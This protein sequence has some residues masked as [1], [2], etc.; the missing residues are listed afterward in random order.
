ME[1][2]GLV[3]KDSLDSNARS[4]TTSDIPCI[5][6]MDQGTVLSG[7]QLYDG[8]LG[9][10]DYG[11]IQDIIDEYEANNDGDVITAEEVEALRDISS[12]FANSATGSKGILHG[13]S[14]RFPE[15]K[16]LQLTLHAGK[17]DQS[18][19]Q[20]LFGIATADDFL[21]QQ[22]YYKTNHLEYWT[23]KHKLL[24]TAY[25]V[26]RDT[27][28]AEDG[29]SPAL[30]F[31]TRG[32][33]VN[34]FSYDGSYRISQ[35]VHTSLE[36]GDEATI[37]L[38]DG[39]N[40]GTADVIDKWYFVNASG[41]NEH[42]IRF[43]NFSVAATETAI[44]NNTVGKFTAAKTGTASITFISPE[45]SNNPSAPV[46][47]TTPLA[48]TGFIF[49]GSNFTN[50]SIPLQRIVT[51]STA[52]VPIYGGHPGEPDVIGFE[53]EIRYHYQY[54]FNFSGLPTYTQNAIKTAGEVHHKIEVTLTANNKT[55]T[56]VISASQI[57]SST[58]IFTIPTLSQSL[59]SLF[60]FLGQ[61]AGTTNLTAT[62]VSFVNKRMLIQNSSDSLNPTDAEGLTIEVTQ[63]DILKASFSVKMPTTSSLRTFCNT[64]NILPRTS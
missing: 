18:V 43:G 35:G 42:R 40:G 12:S 7:Q 41:I 55:R 26:T 48:F 51:I 8:L 16:N 11:S 61:T 45:Y 5:G 47:P 50:Q 15:A 23:A 56:V 19:D 39:S 27:I 3:C 60:G 52:T 24:D 49:S 9:A 44:L 53:E 20:T 31:V 59:E 58:M 22:N 10:D 33:F 1:D 46:A 34:C 2:K 4:Q 36:L 30:S 6:L 21:V 37:T 28:S 14:F 13:Q 38:A 54:T 25:V 62:N 57:D 32:K 64:N 63:E 29:R 17:E